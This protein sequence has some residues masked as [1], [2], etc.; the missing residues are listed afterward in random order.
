VFLGFI[1]KKTGLSDCIANEK[2]SFLYMDDNDDK[3]AAKVLGS[4]SGNYESI[5]HKL[6]RLSPGLKFIFIFGLIHAKKI[7]RI[8]G[9]LI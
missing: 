6:I 4:C 2:S 1:T 8:Q 7:L 9:V 5:D 3:Y